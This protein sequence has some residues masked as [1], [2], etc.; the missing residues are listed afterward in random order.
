MSSGSFRS[1]GAR[2]SNL[3]GIAD[4]TPVNRQATHGLRAKKSDP[5]FCPLVVS[6]EQVE[7]Q[8]DNLFR[9]RADAG[10]KNG[11]KR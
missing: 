6:V 7:C 4:R 2:V 5:G 11:V 3:A 10:R 1:G 8:F 9:S